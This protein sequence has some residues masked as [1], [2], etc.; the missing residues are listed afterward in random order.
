MARLLAELPADAAEADNVLALDLPGLRMVTGYSAD[1]VNPPRGGA[2]STFSMLL[3]TSD[4]A[5]A[6]AQLEAVVRSGKPWAPFP[7]LQ[8]LGADQGS[9]FSVSISSTSGTLDTHV[10]PSRGRANRW[11]CSSCGSP[12]SDPDWL[13][14]D[15]W[16]QA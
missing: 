2:G 14:R 8:A 4:P 7:L 3:S 12:G 15:P 5:F 11:R 16:R 13:H 6:R 9:E 10:V 1:V